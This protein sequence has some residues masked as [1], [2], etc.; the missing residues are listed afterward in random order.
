MV[1][2]KF[3]LRKKRTNVLRETFGTFKFK[4]PVEQMMREIDEDLYDE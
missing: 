2:I 1:E 4:K 3:E